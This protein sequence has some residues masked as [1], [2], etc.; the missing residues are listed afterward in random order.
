V[1]ASDEHLLPVMCSLRGQNHELSRRGSKT[2]RLEC[3]LKRPRVLERT[4]E[5]MRSKGESDHR[6]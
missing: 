4:R 3:S 1:Q 5:S 2:G 6:D